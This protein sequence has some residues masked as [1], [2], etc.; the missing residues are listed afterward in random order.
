MNIQE[1]NY[2]EVVYPIPICRCSECESTLDPSVA[3]WLS[4]NLLSNFRSKNFF[5]FE[6]IGEG[7]R[8]FDVIQF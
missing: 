1:E 5:K 2:A 4:E 6:R 3:I 8:D 7:L